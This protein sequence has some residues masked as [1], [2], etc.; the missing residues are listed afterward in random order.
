MKKVLLFLITTLCCT[1]LWAQ[2][3]A[4]TQSFEEYLSDEIGYFAK[5]YSMDITQAQ[6]NGCIIAGYLSCGGGHEPFFGRPNAIMLNAEGEVEWEKHYFDDESDFDN[7]VFYTFRKVIYHHA[8]NKWFGII[9]GNG[10]SFLTKHHADGEM[11]WSINL[12]SIIGVSIYNVNMSFFNDSNAICLKVIGDTPTLVKF[13]LDGEILWQNQNHISTFHIFADK[14][15]NQFITYDGS[16][17]GVF[18]DKINEENGEVISDYIVEGINDIYD[19]SP[20][21]GGGYWCIG[22]RFG[23]TD[24]CVAALDDNL[25]TLWTK[26]INGPKYPIYSYSYNGYVLSSQLFIGQNINIISTNQKTYFEQINKAL[27]IALDNNFDTLW[28]YQRF[29]NDTLSRI[30]RAIQLDD[31]SIIFTGNYGVENYFYSGAFVFKINV[32]GTVGMSQLIPFEESQAP[33]PNP[34]TDFL[35]THSETEK[36][37]YSIHGQLLWQGTESRIDVSSWSK[38]IYL[39]KTEGEIHKWIKH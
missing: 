9:R 7:Q 32:D 2:E 31:D 18:F 37:I 34:T 12:E 21:V 35:N 19:I 15:N 6:D 33:Y 36:D 38:G 29:K 30:H 13:N 25:D 5:M 20:K 23:S 22:D 10:N 27:V 3:L 39:L 28:T 26:T 1:S 17:N 16:N 24:M 14:V 11:E 4:Y 8:T